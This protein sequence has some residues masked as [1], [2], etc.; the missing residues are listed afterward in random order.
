MPRHTHT[1]NVATA[2]AT[3]QEASSANDSVLAGANVDMYRSGVADT[4]LAPATISSV[5]ASQG[6]DNMQPTLVVSFCIALQGL[7]PSRS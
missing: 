4:S 6:H 3:E 5:G 1:F 2:N 7:F